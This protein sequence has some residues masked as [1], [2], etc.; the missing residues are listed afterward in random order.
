MLQL[1]DHEPGTRALKNFRVI[2]L[3]GIPW[4]VCLKLYIIPGWCIGEFPN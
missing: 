2:N 1:Q 3:K 4:F